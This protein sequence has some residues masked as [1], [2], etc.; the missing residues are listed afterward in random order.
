MAG[1]LYIVSTPIGNLEDITLRAL[2]VLREADVIACE[3]TRTTKKLLDAHEIRTPQVSFHAHSDAGRRAQ[4]LD[5]V[6]AGE[7]VALVSDAG[8]P[9][10]S[11][12]G[13]ELVAEA[14]ADGLPVIPIPGASALL[15][16]LVGAGLPT[17][18][19]LFLGFLPRKAGEQRELLG[20][21]AGLPYTL[22]I[23]ESPR[24]VQDTLQALVAAC[25]GER[26]AV[27]ARELTKRFE[28][29]ARGT[30]ESLVAR[31]AE[32]PKGE[33][34]IVVEGARGEAGAA[35]AQDLR[36][37]VARLLAA[38]TRPSEVAKT[39]A[40]AHG[41]SKKQA[42]RVVLEVQGEADGASEESD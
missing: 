23:Y 34:V 12:P 4:L 14:A 19:V 41:L 5:R 28:T 10:L 15:A 27:V 6:R 9:L 29:F 37:D 30:L 36:A 32:P 22:V 26:P 25:G 31:Y 8:T 13:A 11:D 24:R 1:A 17:H 39:V 2:R 20:P 16:G 35:P 7:S 18:R 3:D 42:Y 40:G 21:V 33:V 38:R